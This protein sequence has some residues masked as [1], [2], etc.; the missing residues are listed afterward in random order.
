MGGV[1]TTHMKNVYLQASICSCE[2][3]L[4]KNQLYIFITIAYNLKT[5]INMKKIT[6]LLSLLFCIIG[7]G[8]TFAAASPITRVDNTTKITAATALDVTKVYMIFSSDGDNARGVLCCTENGN[9]LTRCGASSKT[10]SR[11]VSATDPYQQFVFVPYLGKYYLYNV[12]KKK[13]CK[14]VGETAEMTDAVGQA[15]HVTVTAGTVSGTFMIKF[16]GTDQIALS[17]Q[18]NTGV[19]PSSAATN[20]EGTRLYIAAVDGVTFNTDQINEALNKL[21]NM[22]SATLYPQDGKAYRIKAR[23]NS[24]TTEFRYLYEGDSRI[25]LSSTTKTDNTDI[26]ICRVTD[27]TYS[28]VT[29][30]G[31]WLVYYADGKNGAGDTDNG[32]AASYELGNYDATWTL[33]EN[34]NPT[35]TGLSTTG[36]KQLNLYGTVRMQGRNTT[37]NGNYYLMAGATN[38]SSSD[39]NFHNGEATVTYFTNTRSSFFVFEEVT[40]Y[41]NKPTMTACDNIET[42]KKIATFS[43]PFPTIVPTG[44]SAYII[45]SKS[46]QSAHMEA[47]AGAGEVIPA[48]TGVLLFGETAETKVTMKPATT[49]GTGNSFT[50]TNLLANS[51]GESR[52]ILES[53]NAYILA[54]GGSGIAFYACTSGTLAMNKSFLQIGGGSTNGKAFTL[55]LGGESTGLQTIGNDLWNNNAPIYDLSGRRVMHP[56]KGGVYIQNGRKFINK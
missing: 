26:F 29:N 28:F 8:K 41:P 55:T 30:N 39:G 18:N 48:N 54:S 42:G 6:L 36:A 16:N 35:N 7:I 56:A 25:S 31:K 52:T 51:A 15:Q 53:D 38:E 33:S 50:S 23:Y 11:A 3:S 32:L 27:G 44:L 14:D 4:I 47:I 13:F 43:A 46:T 19:Y 9:N 20:D 37:D 34:L 22:K 5:Y 10:D 12:G 21:L 40:D 49:E 45:S 1:N 2:N 24:T 17:N